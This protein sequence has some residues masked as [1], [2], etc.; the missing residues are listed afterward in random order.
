MPVTSGGAWPAILA[1]SADALPDPHSYQSI[2]W[3][4]VAGAAILAIYNQARTALRGNKP[5]QVE[6]PLKIEHVTQFV[7]VEHFNSKFNEIALRFINIEAQIKDQVLKTDK[8]LHE[9]RHEVRSDLQAMKLTAQE[10]METAIGSVSKVHARVDELAESMGEVRGELKHVADGMKS[11]TNL[12][13]QQG[14]K[15]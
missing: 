7:S 1:D 6:Q 13:I 15:K 12:L 10:N 14:G 9:M 5:T 2:G 11:I 3:L 4:L 8:Y